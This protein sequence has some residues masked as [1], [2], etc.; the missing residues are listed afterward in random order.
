MNCSLAERFKDLAKK[1]CARRAVQKEQLK[2]I[3]QKHHRPG[4][5][6]RDYLDRDSNSAPVQIPTPEPQPEIPKSSGHRVRDCPDEDSNSAPVQK[7]EPTPDLSKDDDA[8]FLR[9]LALGGVEPN[10]P[11]N[12]EP[13]LELLPEK[14]K[15]SQNQKPQSSHMTLTRNTNTSVASQMK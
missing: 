3:I 6:V 12:K 9:Y 1:E 13:E 8:I 10:E 14:K 5:R 2:N 15:N 4:H 11:D 7:S